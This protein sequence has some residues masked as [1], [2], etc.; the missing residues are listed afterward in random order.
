VFTSLTVAAAA[1]DPP[2]MSA[3]LADRS[4]LPVQTLAVPDD[5]DVASTIIEHVHARPGTLLVMATGGTYLL[6]RARRSVTAEVLEGL[7][8]PVLLLG[9]HCTQTAGV[10]GVTLV[11]G[12]DLGSDPSPTLAGVAEWRD[13]FGT[14]PVRLVDIVA[15]SGWPAGSTDEAG[16]ERVDAITTMFA[17]LDADATLLRTDEPAQA[18]VDFGASA[19]A[20]FALPCERWPG[21]SHWYSTS[22]R[23]VQSSPTPVLMLSTDLSQR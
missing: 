6:T 3:R 19:G 14:C 11:V 13:T 15:P 17:D 20:I 21:R 1:A 9:P 4:G 16:R 23:V 5:R 2:T 18:V 8:R 12:I 7:Q 22:R 10:R